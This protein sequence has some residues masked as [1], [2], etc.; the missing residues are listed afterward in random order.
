MRELMGREDLQAQ[1]FC[2]PDRCFYASNFE[3]DV[4]T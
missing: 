4:L 3:L 2:V 1:W